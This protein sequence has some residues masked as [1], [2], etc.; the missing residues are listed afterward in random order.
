[1]L[2]HYT[3]IVLRLWIFSL[4]VFFASSFTSTLRSSFVSKELKKS[5]QISVKGPDIV[6]AGEKFEYSIRLSDVSNLEKC[7]ILFYYC[8]PSEL[9]Y[10]GLARKNSDKLSVTYSKDLKRVFGKISHTGDENEIIFSLKMNAGDNE[11]IRE[12]IQTASY[13][14][15]VVCMSNGEEQ[16]YYK[17]VGLHI[18]KGRKSSILLTEEEK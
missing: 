4:P 13:F 10:E 5:M 12:D 14:I 18:A 6:K 8:P 16:E 15:F 7:D 17:R 11:Q 1:M 3:G 2:S 9:T